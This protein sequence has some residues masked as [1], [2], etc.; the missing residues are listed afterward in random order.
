MEQYYVQPL[1]EFHINIYRMEIKSKL[2]KFYGVFIL[3]IQEIRVFVCT[4]LHFCQN[5]KNKIKWSSN[6]FL[7]IF[8]FDNILR[9]D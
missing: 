6:F 8:G 9:V 4:A 5:L 2:H 1:C 3:I 7:D